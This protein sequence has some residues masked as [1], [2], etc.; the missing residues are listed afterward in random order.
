MYTYI[1]TIQNLFARVIEMY[2]CT[3]VH[4]HMW[5]YEVIIE[6][7]SFRGDYPHLYL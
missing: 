2:V 4:V 7:V 5:P 6:V 1:Y 3:R